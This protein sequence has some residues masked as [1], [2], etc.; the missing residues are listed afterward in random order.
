[1]IQHFRTKLE[2]KT[3]NGPCLFSGG[4]QDRISSG[5]PSLRL[6]ERRNKKVRPNHEGQPL[7]TLHPRPIRLVPHL[8]ARLYVTSTL[9]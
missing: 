6:R 1:M 8:N 5:T 4:E 2:G 3:C 7:V 9:S